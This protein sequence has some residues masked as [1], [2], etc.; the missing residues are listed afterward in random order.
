VFFND[1]NGIDATTQPA[2]AAAAAG[3]PA[4]ESCAALPLS[5]ATVSL[6]VFGT[7]GPD[8]SPLCIAS[9]SMQLNIHDN[10]CEAIFG[11]KSPWF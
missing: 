11:Y 5:S 2:T 7:L 3:S 1:G 4:R 10:C 6:H 9:S 8:F